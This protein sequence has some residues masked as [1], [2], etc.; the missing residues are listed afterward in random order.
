VALLV[1]Y[2]PPASTWRDLF[3]GEE[4]GVVDEEEEGEGLPGGVD[5]GLC[6][7]GTEEESCS[8][9][10]LLDDLLLF[11]SDEEEEEEEL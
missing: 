5:V 11:P 6:L 8:D 2:D 3:L 1:L 4:T 9:D 10:V 7:S